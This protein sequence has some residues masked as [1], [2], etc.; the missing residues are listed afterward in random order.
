MIALSFFN[1]AF[2]GTIA[3]SQTDSGCQLIRET[4]KYWVGVQQGLSYL[5]ERRC[6]FSLG[7]PPF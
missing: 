4:L 1:S 2:I 6:F 3:I 7:W 5:M